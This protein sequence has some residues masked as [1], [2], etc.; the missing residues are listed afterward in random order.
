[1]ATTIKQGFDKL[2]QNLEITNLQ[3]SS[4]STRQQ[5]L[6]EAVEKHLT[7]LDSFLAGSYRRNTLIAPLSEADVDIFIVLDPKYYKYDGQAYL[8]DKMRNALKATYP[9][10]PEI[11]RNGQ[12]VTI[13]F[14]DFCVDVVPAFYRSGG[15][16][17]IPNSIS[18]EWIPTDPKEHVKI[19]SDANKQHNGDLIPL[20]KMFKGWNKKTGQ[21]LRSFHLESLV[22]D[23]LNGVTISD[24][25]SGVRYV[26]DKARARVK[27]P[28][29]DPAGYG[30]HI[31]SYLSTQKKIDDVVSRLETAYSRAKT[32]EELAS[33]GKVSEA[34]DKWRLI[35]DTYF[36]AYG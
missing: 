34:T 28:I 23:I 24:F 6:R 29:I 12:A 20:I 2:K 25:P 35:F 32:A 21:L 7:V 26:F 3:E 1:L 8:L 18:Q 19:W 5:I 27:S 36:P 17:L 31:G 10:T 30:G 15:G 14:T 33:K 22:I 11:S 13:T 4:V 16:Y 9:R